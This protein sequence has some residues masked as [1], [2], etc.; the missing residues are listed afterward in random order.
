MSCPTDNT[1]FQRFWKKVS[2]DGPIPEKCPELGPCWL[3]LAFKDEHGRGQ[4]ATSKGLQHAHTV[5][6]ILHGREIPDGMCLLHRCD[7]MGCPN[8]D[9]LRIGTQI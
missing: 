7:N 8:P 1:L 9:H 3:W 5:S 6:W 4:I 2:K